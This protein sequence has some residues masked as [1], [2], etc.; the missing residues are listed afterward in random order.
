M[1]PKKMSSLKTN[2]ELPNIIES[3]IESNNINTLIRNYEKSM[4]NKANKS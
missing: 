1:R 2:Q 4:L 3:I